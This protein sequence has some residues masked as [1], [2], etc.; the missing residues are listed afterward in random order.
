MRLCT[1]DEHALVCAG[2]GCNYDNK[3]IWTSDG[4][5]NWQCYLD[6]YPGL[7]NALGANNVAAAERHYRNYGKKEGRICSCASN[8]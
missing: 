5:C 2:T 3:L 4:E 8:L 1:Q 6:R 7:Q